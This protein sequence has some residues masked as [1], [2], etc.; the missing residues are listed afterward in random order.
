MVQELS[1]K[2]NLTGE[3]GGLWYRMS[4]E[5]MTGGGGLWYKN[6]SNDGG[7]TRHGS[8]KSKGGGGGVWY[9]N[10]SEK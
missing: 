5:S 2:S 1:V 8:V 4:V 9:K 6:V 7:S 3:Q 10:V